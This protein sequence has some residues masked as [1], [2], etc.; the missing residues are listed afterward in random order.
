MLTIFATVVVL[1]SRPIG[2]EHSHYLHIVQNPCCVEARRL[3]D[4]GRL[5][6][7]SVQA[8]CARGYTIALDAE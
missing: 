7:G 6:V 1:P 8:Q 2:E 4:C 3:R 5:A